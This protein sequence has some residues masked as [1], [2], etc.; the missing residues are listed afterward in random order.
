MNQATAKLQI[1]IEPEL[2]KTDQAATADQPLPV[3]GQMILKSE[4]REERLLSIHGALTEKE[5][6]RL[7][8]DEKKRERL[9]LADQPRLISGFALLKKEESKRPSSHHWSGSLHL[10]SSD[11]ETQYKTTIVLKK[12]DSKTKDSAITSPKTSPESPQGL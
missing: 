7:R 10:S 12:V 8:L 11:G 5:I 6:L 3:A 2:R 1:T 9:P 4:L